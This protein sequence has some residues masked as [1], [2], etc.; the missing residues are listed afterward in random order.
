MTDLKEMI[1][2]RDITIG[3]P[4]DFSLPRIQIKFYA[5]RKAGEAEGSWPADGFDSLQSVDIVDSM[6]LTFADTGKSGVRI[7]ELVEDSS[8]N[9]HT[10]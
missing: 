6:N 8:A 9:T 5:E 7:E 3:R 4:K 2:L 10:V 1:V